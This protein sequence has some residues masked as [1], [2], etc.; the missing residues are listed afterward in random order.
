MV[1]SLPWNRS[2]IV[3]YC[4]S[5]VD[6]SA[7]IRVSRLCARMHSINGAPQQYRKMPKFLIAEIRRFSFA[8]L[9]AL[10][11]QHNGFK[12]RSYEWTGSW[13]DIQRLR[14]PSRILTAFSSQLALTVNHFFGSVRQN[15]VLTNFRGSTHSNSQHSY[16]CPLLTLQ[17]Q[18]VI[19][20]FVS[21]AQF[22]LP[23]GS[24][25]PWTRS[26]SYLGKNN[27]SSKSR[28]RR[29]TAIQ[30]QHGFVA[31]RNWCDEEIG[32]IPIRNEYYN[33]STTYFIYFH[34][35]IGIYITA[36]QVWS[37]AC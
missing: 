16:R 14:V 2:N 20:S 29:L 7:E 26:Q 24:T 18:T 25:Y 33:C 21:S 12:R 15:K 36:S 11:C 31:I 1:E 22:Y 34:H 35:I 27:L 23:F 4:Y 10:Y 13:S 37:T 28:H 19:P 9:T 17:V 3:S 8:L 30:L 6:P 32:K 5:W